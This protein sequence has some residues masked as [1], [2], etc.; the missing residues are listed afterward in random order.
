M[1]C[2]DLGVIAASLANGG[3]NPVTG[4]RAVSPEVAENILSVMMTCG[5]YDY[6]GEWVYRIGLPAKSGVAGGILAVLPGQLGIGV[7]SPPL[8]ARGNSVRG[9]R[10]CEVLSR[11]LHL[12]SLLPPRPLV[13][14]VRSRYSLATIRSKRRRTKSEGRILDAHGARIK[15]YELQGDLRFSAVE[16]IIREIVEASADL[17]VAI[18]DLRRV[19]QI[20]P[21]AGHMLIEL[22]RSL[23]VLGNTSSSRMCKD[24]HSSGGF[25]RK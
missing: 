10:V 13:S 16:V 5:M 11:D 8:D 7:F 3:V 9:V 1:N 15:V 17:T 14:A 18:V 23:A 2:R 6:A 12:H 22:V 4:E 20:D 19:T 25:W 21:P 24:T